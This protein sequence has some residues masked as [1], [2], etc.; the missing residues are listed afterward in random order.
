MPKFSKQSLDKLHT[1]HREL[2]VLFAE[3]VQHF[4]CTVVYGHRTVE[5]QQELYAKGRTKPGGIVTYCDGVKNLSKH[6]YTP[7]LAVDVVPYPSLYSDIDTIR[8][9][10]GYVLGQAD[11]LYDMGILH[12]KIICGIDWDNDKD[13]HDQRLFDA[14]H[15]QVQL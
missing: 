12:N 9:F 6:N 4:D 1:A 14:V 2:Q 8:H 3:V 7:S 10:A 13:L 11:A 5:E 15:F